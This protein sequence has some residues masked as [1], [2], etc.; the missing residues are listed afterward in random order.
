VKLTPPYHLLLFS[1]R[2]FHIH[3]YSQ[4]RQPKRQC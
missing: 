2:G 4:G 3:S 1:Y